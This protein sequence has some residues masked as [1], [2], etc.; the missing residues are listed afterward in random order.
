VSKSR[1]KLESSSLLKPQFLHSD[2]FFINSILYT[3]TQNKRSVTKDTTSCYKDMMLNLL[4]V[5]L[6]MLPLQT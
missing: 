2:E 3:L 6:K 5:V 1:R 4:L